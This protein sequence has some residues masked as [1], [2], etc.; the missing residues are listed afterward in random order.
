[1]VSEGMSFVE[2]VSSYRL[3][4]YFSNLVKRDES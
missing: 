3:S 1:M 4:F 2:I